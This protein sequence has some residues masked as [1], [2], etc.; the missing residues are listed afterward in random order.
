MRFILC[1]ALLLVCPTRAV[2]AEESSL[3]CDATDSLVTTM[4]DKV[5]GHIG[6]CLAS[7][8]NKPRICF[9]LTKEFDGEPRFT[10]VILFGTA[11]KD[12]KVT[13]SSGSIESDGSVTKTTDIYDIGK[14]KVPLTV[15]TKS[16]TQ[17]SG[18]TVSKVVVGD[19][20]LVRDPPGVGIVDLTGEAPAYKFV[21]AKLPNCSVKLSD[22]EHKT[23]AKAIDEAIAELKKNSDEIKA[24]AD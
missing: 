1:A 23:W 19:V 12:V 22:K 24:L 13:G 18:F 7:Q 11:K 17:P 6:A 4:G 8:D 14:Y 15:E 5:A 3:N 21:N 10:F 20:N 2:F 16:G 9:G